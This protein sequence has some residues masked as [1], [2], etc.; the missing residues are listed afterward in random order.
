VADVR[1]P[2]PQIEI[3]DTKAGPS[4][5]DG[6]ATT[7][8]PVATAATSAPDLDAVTSTPRLTGPG[9]KAARRTHE[10]RMDRATLGR[11]YKG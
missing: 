8:I 1:L 10:P 2:Y 9:A 6:E 4:V 5:A 7:E 3:I 11:G